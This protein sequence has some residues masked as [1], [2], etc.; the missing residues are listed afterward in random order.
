MASK[1]I[2]I[3]E[4]ED[5]IREMVAFGLGR[6]GFET[7]EAADCSQARRAIAD[8]VPDLVLLD[9]MLPD[10]SGIEFARALRRDANTKHLPIVML[11]ARA[12]E[13]DKVRGLDS[14][15]DEAL[16]ESLEVG[17]VSG[18]NKSSDKERCSAG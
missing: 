18:G 16:T 6:A 5:A 15:I 7:T 13:D 10:L 8:R 1:H 3:V 9:W 14:G 2:L 11:T 4:D 12:D 17:I